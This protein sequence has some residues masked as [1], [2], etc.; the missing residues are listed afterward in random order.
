MAPS[1]VPYYGR[2]LRFLL[3]YPGSDAMLPIWT[4][5][6]AWPHQDRAVN[7][8]NEEQRKQLTA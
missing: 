2:W 7:A 1:H 6:P 8:A 3:F 4:K 5:D